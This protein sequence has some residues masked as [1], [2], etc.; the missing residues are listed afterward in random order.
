MRYWEWRRTTAM[1]L[2]AIVPMSQ[3]GTRRRCLHRAAAVQSRQDEDSRRQCAD[4]LIYSAAH[5]ILKVLP[6]SSKR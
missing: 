4:W 5:I 6:R 1:N 3:P 2:V